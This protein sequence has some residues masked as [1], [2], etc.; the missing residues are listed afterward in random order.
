MREAKRRMTVRVCP[1]AGILP[2]ETSAVFFYGNIMK[3]NGKD[4]LQWLK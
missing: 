3:S 2:R 4:M 1:I